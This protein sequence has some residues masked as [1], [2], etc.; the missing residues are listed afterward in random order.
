MRLINVESRKIEAFFGGSI[1]PY[2]ILSHTWG[3]E[4]VSFEEYTNEAYHDEHI[5]RLL[6]DPCIML[7]SSRGRSRVRLDRYLLH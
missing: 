2:A 6:E 7:T 5:Y 4:E 1:P 3:V